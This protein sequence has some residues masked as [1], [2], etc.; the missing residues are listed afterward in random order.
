MQNI[1]TNHGMMGINSIIDHLTYSSYR[2]NRKD[3]EAE[4][5][6]KW[7]PNAEALEARYQLELKQKK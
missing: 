7:Y 3:S 4:L 2:T 1:P 5:L 6:A